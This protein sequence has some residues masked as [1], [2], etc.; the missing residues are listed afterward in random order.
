M[1]APIVLPAGS[2]PE[3]ALILKSIVVP[4]FGVVL[5]LTRGSTCFLVRRFR[6]AVRHPRRV[7][8]V[9]EPN[10]HSRRMMLAE[11]TWE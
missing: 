2:S 3:T 10:F 8:G 5:L 6:F 1:G 11:E 9:R 7:A 4:I